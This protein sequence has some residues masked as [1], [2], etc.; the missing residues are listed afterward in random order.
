MGVKLGLLGNKDNKVKGLY[1]GRVHPVAHV[2]M[3]SRLRVF[4]SRV[5]RTTF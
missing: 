2:T 3:N 4:G 5:M 1:Y